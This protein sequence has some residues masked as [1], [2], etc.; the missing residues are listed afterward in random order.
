MKGI[1]IHSKGISLIKSYF[2][3]MGG[4]SYSVDKWLEI[5][6]EFD[7]IGISTGKRVTE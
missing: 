1:F 7:I 2:D 3:H 5:A 4:I 6:L